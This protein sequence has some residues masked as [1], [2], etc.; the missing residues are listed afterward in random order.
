MSDEIDKVERSYI[1][2]ASEIGGSVI[3]DDAVYDAK[4]VGVEIV[5]E[6]GCNNDGGELVVIVDDGVNITAPVA[7]GLAPRHAAVGE[8]FTLCGF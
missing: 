1:T 8:R 6:A 2:L 4:I 7:T 3:I 5:N